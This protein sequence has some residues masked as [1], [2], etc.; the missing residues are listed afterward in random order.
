MVSNQ[1]ISES[2]KVWI[3]S[4]LFALPSPLNLHVSK[5][6]KHLGWASDQRPFDFPL[7]QACPLVSWRMAAGRMLGTVGMCVVVALT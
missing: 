2:S 4:P 5:G 3:P 1:I 7:N 6:R